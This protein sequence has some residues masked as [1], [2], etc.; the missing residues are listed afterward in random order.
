MTS[1]SNNLIR[2]WPNPLGEGRRV[3]GRMPAEIQRLTVRGAT[4]VRIAASRTDK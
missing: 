1:K 3:A 4:P 2:S